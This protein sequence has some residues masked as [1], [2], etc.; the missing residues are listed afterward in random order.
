MFLLKNQSLWNIFLGNFAY[1]SNWEPKIHF[2]G[3]IQQYDL[4]T[5][6]YRLSAVRATLRILFCTLD[7]AITGD[8]IMCVDKNELE[9]ILTC[10]STLHLS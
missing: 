4:C 2:K 7:K 3:P 1:L 10:N 5:S 9:V 6:V 8:K